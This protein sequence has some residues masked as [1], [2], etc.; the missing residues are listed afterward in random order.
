MQRRAELARLVDR[1]NYEVQEAYEQAVESEKVLA[2]YRDTT[3]PAARRNVELATTEYAVAKV[4][5]LNLIEAQRNL[6]ELRNRQLET[7]AELVRRRAALERAVGG[8]APMTTQPKGA[9]PLPQPRQLPEPKPKLEPKP[10]EARGGPS[11]P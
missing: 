8:L 5:F 3:L 7:A 9:R 2:L 1:V 11:T 6:I 4:P 10:P